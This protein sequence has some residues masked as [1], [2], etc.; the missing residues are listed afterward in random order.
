ME[1]GEIRQIELQLEELHRGINSLI[2]Q[3]QTLRGL[4]KSLAK[5]QSLSFEG[6]D[7]ILL[8]GL[9]DVMQEEEERIDPD[10]VVKETLCRAADPD[11]PQ[12]ALLQ[13]AENGNAETRRAVATNPNTTGTLLEKLGRDPDE[14]VREA[15]REVQEGKALYLE[16]KKMLGQIDPGFLPE[17][18]LTIVSAKNW[19]I[20]REVAANPNTPVEV[21]LKLGKDESELVRHAVANN[22]NIPLKL[23]KDLAKDESYLVSTKASQNIEKQEKRKE[24]EEQRVEKD[25]VGNIRKGHNR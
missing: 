7:A 11:T 16:M 17:G 2:I 24:Q 25:I 18:L 14:S 19:I 21:L 20:C 8:D 10:T 5:S 6:M 23:L 12:A 9:K 22:P 3:N 1:R 4:V 15:V 13:M